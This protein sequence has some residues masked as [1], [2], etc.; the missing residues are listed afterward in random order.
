MED[1]AEVIV[2]ATERYDKS[3]PV[4]IGSGFEIFIEN[5]VTTIGEM[6]GYRGRVVWDTTKP[7]GQPERF[8]DTTKAKREFGFMARIDL[9][10]GLRRTVN[11]Y[12]E[13]GRLTVA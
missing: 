12:H 1:A 7:N 8:L 11:W 2:L 4:N 9:D 13:E 3:D 6:T 10:E 5:L